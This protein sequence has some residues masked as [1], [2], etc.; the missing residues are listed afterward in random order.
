MQK[1][2]QESADTARPDEAPE[3]VSIYR[4]AA[5]LFFPFQNVLR[6]LPNLEYYHHENSSSFHDIIA[7]R[8]IENFLISLTISM[9]VTY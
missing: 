9:F 7:L 4:S 6:C 2:M 8:V 1:E 3:H 5:I